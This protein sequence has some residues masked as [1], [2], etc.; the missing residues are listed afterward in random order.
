[1]LRE[2]ERELKLTSQGYVQWAQDKKGDHWAKALKLINQLE[3]DLIPP[4]IP[5]LGPIWV[6]GKSILLHDLTHKT[7][8]IARFPAFDDAFNQGRVVIAPERMVVT[9]PPTSSLPGEAF[10]TKGT[11]KLLYWF[12]HLDRDHPNGTWFKKGEA[13]GKVAANNI[14]GGPHVHVGINIEMLAG[15][16]KELIHHNDYSHGAPLIGTQLRRLMEP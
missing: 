2:A 14:G 1:M 6:G 4:P 15:D 5:Q 12:G 9:G 3:R 7:A 8:G 11:S 10:F 13:I 16:G